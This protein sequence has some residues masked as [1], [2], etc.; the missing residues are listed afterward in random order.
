MRIAE[1]KCIA[2]QSNKSILIDL[3]D[4]KAIHLTSAIKKHFT[5]KDYSLAL[6]NITLTCII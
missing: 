2:L 4:C 5:L 1:V 3:F 6:R